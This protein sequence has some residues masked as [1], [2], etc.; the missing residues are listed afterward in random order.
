MSGE[1]DR[2]KRLAGWTKVES[3]A[4]EVRCMIQRHIMSMRNS[5]EHKRFACWFVLAAS[6]MT[7]PVLADD[8]PPPP[9]PPPGVGPVP[10]AAPVGTGTLEAPPPP[11]PGVK[12][13]P[14]PQAVPTTQTPLPAPPQA[15]PT[16]SV[17][18]LS[19]PPPPPPGVEPPPTKPKR[20]RKPS[21]SRPTSTPLVNTQRTN[22]SPDYT[23]KDRAN[24]KTKWYGWHSLIGVVPLQAMFGAGWAM[25][26]DQLI[27]IGALGS[28]LMS[29]IVH[30]ANGQDGRGWAS[31]GGNVGSLLIGGLIAEEVGVG[32]GLVLW[33]TIDISLLHYKPV[34]PQEPPKSALGIH[35]F[36]VVPMMEKGRQGLSIMGQF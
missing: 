2:S 24:P 22:T 19:E 3:S 6:M 27:F 28:I 25:N 1:L 4:V 11:P 35:S 29:P 31:L 15:A 26:N 33:T 30:R 21:L 18:G 36:A 10:S 34:P 5:L 8:L 23:W 32:I 7:S 20:P 14:T 17:P 12:I 9:P 13:E 16:S